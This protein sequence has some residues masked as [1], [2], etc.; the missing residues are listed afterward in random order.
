M[1]SSQTPLSLVTGA[2]ALRLALPGRRIE[3]QKNT[4]SDHSLQPDRVF[5]RVRLDLAKYHKPLDPERFY[6]T[7]DARESNDQEV[8]RRLQS[9]TAAPTGVEV[10]LL[11]AE[12]QRPPWTG[13]QYVRQ[14]CGHLG[15]ITVE[16][17]DPPTSAA[18]L[19]ALRRGQ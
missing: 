9:L 14:E 12:G 16:C 3:A 15:S 13:V 4:N 11:V 8:T 7:R 6:S 18:W 10:V 17:E 2:F 1:A 19:W 5:G